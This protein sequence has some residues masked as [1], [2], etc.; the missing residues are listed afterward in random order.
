MAQSLSE[1]FS[2]SVFIG[3]ERD[4]KR[5]NNTIDDEIP[6]VFE[7]ELSSIE[8]KI[9]ALLNAYGVDVKSGP[10]ALEQDNFD[11][12]LRKLSKIFSL[13][14]NNHNW[15][16]DMCTLSCYL[17][18]AKSLQYA[19]SH[20][21][22]CVKSTKK[23]LG[24]EQ[25]HNLNPTISLEALS[26]MEH[27]I[28]PKID[29][30]DALFRDRLKD[31]SL[32]FP[33]I[34]TMCMI[35]NFLEYSLKLAQCTACPAYMEGTVC[36]LSVIAYCL[37]LFQEGLKQFSNVSSS[38][39]D[40]ERFKHITT[41]IS[42]LTKKVN[43]LMAAIQIK[44]SQQFPEEYNKKEGGEKDGKRQETVYG[45]G[46]GPFATNNARRRGRSE[47]SQ[48]RAR[49]RAT[50][51]ATS[52][53][54]GTRSALAPPVKKR[55]TADN[56][57]GWIRSFTQGVSHAVA[58][59]GENLF[60]ADSRK[61]SKVTHE[62]RKCTDTIPSINNT[63]TI[64]SSGFWWDYTKLLTDAWNKYSFNHENSKKASNFLSTATV[65][66]KLQPI[67]TDLLTRSGFGGVRPSVPKIMFKAVQSMV[68]GTH[69]F[70]DQ[71]RFMTIFGKSYES[72]GDF[73]RGFVNAL[74]NGFPSMY[75]TGN[76]YYVTG[77]PIL[78]KGDWN[79]AAK[80]Y[81]PTLNE[82]LDSKHT[83]SPFQFAYVSKPLAQATTENEWELH[84]DNILLPYFDSEGDKYKMKLQDIFWKEREG[85]THAFWSLPFMLCCAI[86][87]SKS[88]SNVL[89]D[90][91]D[92]L[93]FYEKPAEERRNH[94]VYFYRSVAVILQSK[95][96]E[97][98]NKNVYLPY[99]WMRSIHDQ[100]WTSYGGR[101]SRPRQLDETYTTHRK[102][103]IQAIIYQYYGMC[104][105]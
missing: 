28:S 33:L 86:R 67:Y 7:K 103:G 47:E 74:Y 81:G 48:G 89:L 101:H 1:D 73:F 97:T 56:D 37:E 16:E 51:T 26:R 17:A 63:S 69:E 13:M 85:Q 21:G 9:D 22:D 105:V 58:S 31:I 79:S 96:V 53:N 29:Q 43:H 19:L 87:K 104:K 40:G 82:G 24:D 54:A 41:K 102:G 55:K 84:I 5:P 30:I 94:L 44:L 77:G 50:A 38:H 25:Y 8:Q 4:E 20:Q 75:E 83:G 100:H 18:I 32:E 3:P 59:V 36:A 98:A 91:P 15:T 60:G 88:G 23:L 64:Y 6:I 46:P 52:S 65:L 99:A 95:C 72:Y 90:C 27:N 35:K 93:A 12:F 71:V 76:D 11:V 10:P 49:A 45:G 66:A 57:T 42:A 92:V 62:F 2:S 80:K 34:P 78:P 68:Y 70:P 61:S 39:D 14:Q